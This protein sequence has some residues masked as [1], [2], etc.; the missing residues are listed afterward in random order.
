MT[1]LYPDQPIPK[2]SMRSSGVPQ[3]RQISAW[4]SPH[5]NGSE[6]GRVQVG[7]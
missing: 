7:Q 2:S 1:Q 6:T 4:Q 5:I 3:T